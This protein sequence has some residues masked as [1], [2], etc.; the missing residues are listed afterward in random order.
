VQIEPVELWQEAA[1]AL[2]FG[3]VSAE[4]TTD[5]YKRGMARSFA[6]QNEMACTAVARP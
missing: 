2:I 1:V 3:F 6:L 4:S 5:A